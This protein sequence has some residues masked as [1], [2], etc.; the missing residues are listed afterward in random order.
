MYAKISK[1][2]AEE[3]KKF[4]IRN[5]V[6]VKGF[7][8]LHSNSYVLYPVD[9]KVAKIKKLIEKRGG[10]L[11]ADASGSSTAALPEAAA[12]KQNFRMPGYDILGNI[13]VVEIPD[14]MEG[15][16]GAISKA[17]M[18][19]HKGVGT[20]LAKAG[21]VTGIYRT[22]KLKY[23]AG[24]RSYIAT[25]RENGCTFRFNVRDV[26]F[27][28]R[29]SYERAR[30]ASL[31]SPR[32]KV[33]VMFAGAGPFA[34]E[35]A[36]RQPSAE[37]IA[38]DINRKA[39]EWM[40]ENVSINKT[41]NVTPVLGDVDAVAE[42]YAGFADRIVMPLPKSSHLHMRSALLMAKKKA[43]I[44]VYAFG[45]TEGAAADTAKEVGRLADE[46]GYSARSVFSR[47][48]RNY[49]PKENEV[50]VD[51]IVRKRDLRKRQ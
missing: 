18:E 50:V 37:V 34:I 23:V 41:S 4:L 32:E 31:A 46:I 22:R 45:S 29:L 19:S 11:V 8:V 51:F 15:E 24:K 33:I 17:I 43:V 36:K 7:K 26:F 5:S 13:S 49:S 2:R 35:I 12:K 16:E 30:I 3:L 20:V 40:K 6:L 21:P 44:H 25:Y 27:S 10:T 28:S 14:G 38:I 9:I 48:V 39:F 42:K 1:D 47:V